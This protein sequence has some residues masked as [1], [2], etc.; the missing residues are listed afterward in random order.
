MPTHVFA[1]IIRPR[2]HT[3]V[4]RPLPPDV[5]DAY[6]RPWA[7]QAGQERW[8]DQVVSVSH[9]DTTEVVDRLDQLAAPTL[10][11]WGEH[12]TWLTP[13]VGRRLAAAIPAARLRTVPAAGH[14]LPED[15]PDA[16]AD[17]L[18]QHLAV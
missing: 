3:A 14:F 17:A 8:V 9:T 18:L 16:V 10:V 6:L 2:L 13:D 11:L 5:L 12:D 7:G 1:D 15:A 4:H